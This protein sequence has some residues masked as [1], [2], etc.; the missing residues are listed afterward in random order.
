MTAEG[1][2]TNPEDMAIVNS[3]DV[4]GELG[5]FATQCIDFASFSLDPDCLIEKLLEKHDLTTECGMCFVDTAVCGADYCLTEC[6]DQGQDCIDCSEEAGC[7]DALE[8]CS[9]LQQQ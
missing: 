2:C 3:I 7:V 6:M 4:Q 5:S 1:A 9:G 8:E